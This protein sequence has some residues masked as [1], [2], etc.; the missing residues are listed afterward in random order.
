MVYECQQASFL[1]YYSDHG[2]NKSMNKVPMLAGI[3]IIY[4]QQYGPPLT[5]ADLVNATA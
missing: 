3:D 5:K 4:G 2:L 1:I